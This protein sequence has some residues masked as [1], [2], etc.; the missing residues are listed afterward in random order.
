M[1]LKKIS[2]F[3]FFLLL[4]YVSLKFSLP[5]RLGKKYTKLDKI[6][7]INL[8]KN[9][10]RLVAI[11]EALQKQN[12]K[13]ERFDAINGLDIKMENQKGEVFYG[14]DIK[15]GKY[16]FKIGEKYKI[17]CPNIV[18]NYEYKPAYYPVR[19]GPMVPGEFGCMCSH[20][21]IM[22]DV[23][24]N[25]YKFVIVL[26]DDTIIPS[27]FE[28]LK[29]KIENNLPHFKDYDI[30]YLGYSK[31]STIS[32]LKFKNLLFN[33]EI[34]KITSANNKISGTYALAYSYFGAANMLSN[35]DANKPI[36]DSISDAIIKNKISAYK[37]KNYHLKVNTNF[38]SEIDQIMSR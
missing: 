13:F 23:L 20:Y 30:L 9:N 32:L 5:K 27:N 4:I 11:T 35:I 18:L 37:L 2:F 6:Y 12:L 8:K 26:E 29:V 7:V 10:D 34:Q 1:V 17:Y 3:L 21:E 31:K 38:E 28:E 25:R 24:K 14:K 33:S 19:G 16:S 15:S 36:D 22:L